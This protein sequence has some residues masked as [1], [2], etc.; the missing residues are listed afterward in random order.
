MSNELYIT[1]SGAPGSGKTT[2][3]EVIRRA[4][5]QIMVDVTVIDRDLTPQA[6]QRLEERD[7]VAMA[8]QLSSKRVFV[9]T[10]QLSRKPST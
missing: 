8:Q 5:T 9:S 7:L 6:H 2:L 4:L 1:V 3:A 10:Q